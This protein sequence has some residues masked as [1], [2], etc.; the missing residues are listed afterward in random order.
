[1]SK[2][3]RDSNLSGSCQENNSGKLAVSYI[4]ISNSFDCR[5]D[6]CFMQFQINMKVCS[7]NQFS[8]IFHFYNSLKPPENLTFS[9]GIEMEHRTKIG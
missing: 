7:L 5:L 9:G 4:G 1:M 2:R 8:L 3:S 6:Q